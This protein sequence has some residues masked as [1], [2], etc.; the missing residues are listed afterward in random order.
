[1][2]SSLFAAKVTRSFGRKITMGFGALLF[3]A[4][5]LVNALAQDVV[6]EEGC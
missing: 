5:G 4:G 1:M 3:I 6:S 2:L